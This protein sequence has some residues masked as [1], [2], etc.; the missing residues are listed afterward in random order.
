MLFRKLQWV[1]RSLSIPFLAIGVAKNTIHMRP[2]ITAKT[3]KETIVEA[4]HNAI[5]HLHR[6]ISLVTPDIFCYI[7]IKILDRNEMQVLL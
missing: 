6:K 4:L 7:Y 2:P 5:Y 1:P 3:N